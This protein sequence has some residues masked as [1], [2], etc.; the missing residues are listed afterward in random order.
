MVGLMQTKRAEWDEILNQLGMIMG[1]AVDRMKYVTLALCAAFAAMALTFVSAPAMAQ[2]ADGAGEAVADAAVVEEAGGYTPMAPTEGKGMPTSYEDDWFK[3]LTFQD[4]Y[5]DNGAYALGMH[6]YVLM[7]VITV[8]SLFVLF[9][10]L[11]VVVKFRKGANPVPSKTTHNT[12]IEVVWTVV[13]ALILVFIAV[14]SIT[15][16]ARQYETPPADAV[17]IKAV[18]Y[19]WYWGYEYPDH[20][21]EVISNMLNNPNDPDISPNKRMA[22]SEPWDGP[23]L[24]EVDNRMVVPAGVPL[25]I[26][27][28]AADVIH[29]FAV[30]ALWFKQD[31]VP[32]RLNEKMLLIEEPGVY[33]GQ[34]SEL[35][36]SR[37]GYMPI[38]VEA[39]PVEEFEAWVLEQGGTLPGAEEV[40]ADTNAGANAGDG[41]AADVAE[42]ADAA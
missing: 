7:P 1:Q 16:L 42:E 30:P 17:T 8:I 34:C 39:L 40:A 6:D 41:V 22:G 3:S 32:G 24:L 19:Q 13:P 14:P 18:G 36:G 29:A 31:A 33:Y 26:Q 4:Q 9:L 35:C 15:L 38:A 11:Y 10:L 27:T 2:D 5:T 23:A 20:D 12:A 21:V 25:R 37:H 28:T